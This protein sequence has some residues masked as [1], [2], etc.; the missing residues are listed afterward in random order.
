VRD[1]IIILNQH[2]EFKLNPWR[3]V[4]RN[5]N[6]QVDGRQHTHKKAYSIRRSQR[7]AVKQRFVYC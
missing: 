3:S 2:T 1:E 6:V 7:Y 5:R 4:L